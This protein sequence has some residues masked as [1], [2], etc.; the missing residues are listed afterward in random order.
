LVESETGG[1]LRQIHG[2]D[3]KEIIPGA[4]R[5]VFDEDDII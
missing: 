2:K 3:N 1:H 4:V 5:V